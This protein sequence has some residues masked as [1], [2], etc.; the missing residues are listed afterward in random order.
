MKTNPKITRQSAFTVVELY[1]V[2]LIIAIIVPVGLSCL[3]RKGPM[4]KGAQCRS[5]LKQLVFSIKIYAG[6]HEGQFPWGTADV[7]TSSPVNKQVWQYMC[8]ISNE[9]GSSRVLICPGD[10]SR[11][12]N[13]ATAFSSGAQGLANPA[14]QDSAVSYFLGLSASSN[15]PNA[16]MSGDRNVAPAET[17]SLY[18]GRGAKA[19]EVATN[20]AWSTQGEQSFHD[21]AGNYALADGSVQQ[22]SNARLQEALRLARDSY[23]TNANRFLFPQ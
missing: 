7:P 10:I 1:F 14:K 16:I 11:L 4:A 15:K 6:D 8:A 19:V 21:N 13:M 12:D 5:N 23:G 17:G 3:N 9:L 2:I 18:V 22:S 20:A